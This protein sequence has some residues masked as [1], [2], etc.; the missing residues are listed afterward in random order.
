LP[1]TAGGHTSNELNG[2][3]AAMDP[4]TSAFWDAGTHAPGYARALVSSFLVRN[5]LQELIPTATLLVSELVTNS[6]LHAGGRI[7]LHACWNNPTLRV[8]VRD[9]SRAPARLRDQ[10]EEGGRGLQIVDELATNWA[11]EPS[12]DNGKVTWFEI[13]R[14]PTS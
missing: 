3:E 12:R 14:T 4:E 7:G 10:H 13:K 2:Q 8:E 11:S 6:V 9:R 1:L 5:D